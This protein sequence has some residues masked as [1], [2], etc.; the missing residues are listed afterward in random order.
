MLKSI[1]FGA[2]IA[3]T[4][5]LSFTPA[6]AHSPQDVRHLLQDRG[7]SNIE[8]LDTSPPLYMANAC[9]D[10][11]RYHFHVDYY[12]EVTERRPIGECEN[13]EHHHRWQWR[14]RSY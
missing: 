2:T 3:A 1:L 9:R 10:G 6:N 14:H 8:F 11:V 13:H 5:L 4:G 7:Y 12:G